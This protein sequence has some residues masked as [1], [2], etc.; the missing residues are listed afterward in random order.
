MSADNKN[1]L[2]LQPFSGC[3][4]VLVLFVFVGNREMIAQAAAGVV[5]M[6]RT[7]GPEYLCALLMRS[8]KQ[9]RCDPLHQVFHFLSAIRQVSCVKTDWI[10][11]TSELLRPSHILSFLAETC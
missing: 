10:L 3:V 6:T 5:R 8:K 11:S 2:L 9:G 4:K 1:N 7:N